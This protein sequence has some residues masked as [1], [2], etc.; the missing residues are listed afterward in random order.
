VVNNVAKSLDESKEE[1]E[2]SR[3]GQI[4]REMGGKMMEYNYSTS[5][6]ERSTSQ[7]PQTSHEALSHCSANGDEPMINNKTYQDISVLA[8]VDLLW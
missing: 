7:P 3:V 4:R 1:V 2:S 8:I 5:S 6:R